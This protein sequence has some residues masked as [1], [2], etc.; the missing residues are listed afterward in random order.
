MKA[1]ILV[2]TTLSLFSLG[3]HA[4]FSKVESE[5][6]SQIN[7]ESQVKVES[8]K[9]LLNIAQQKQ[10]K[11]NPESKELIDELRNSWDVTIKKRCNLETSESKGTDAEVSAV[12]NCLAKG[13]AEELDYFNNMLP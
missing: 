7:S 8:V 5:Q 6:L 11:D 13:Y 2:L 3:C 9:S 4:A 12:N 1:N 10:I